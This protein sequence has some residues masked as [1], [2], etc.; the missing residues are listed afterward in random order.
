MPSCLTPLS[1]S[2]FSSGPGK[3]PVPS[4]WPQSGRVPRDPNFPS[5]LPFHTSR[6]HRPGSHGGLALEGSLVQNNH[7]LLERKYFQ[8]LPFFPSFPGSTG[9]CGAPLNRYRVFYVFKYLKSFFFF[10]KNRIWGT[11]VCDISISKP[12]FFITS[13]LWCQTIVNGISGPFISSSL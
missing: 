8:S 7:F 9:K 2:V 4:A 3:T 6:Q 13:C 5:P 11:F 12:A 1:A 10:L